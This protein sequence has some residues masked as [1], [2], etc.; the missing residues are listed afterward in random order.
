MKREMLKGKF[1]LAMI[2]GLIC[3]IPYQEAFAWGGDRTNRGRYY[4]HAGRFYRWGD[5]R[6]IVVNPPLGAIVTALPFGYVSV[7][8][9]GVRYYRYN[10]V[11][12]RH[13]PSGYVIVAD[14][15]VN[16]NIAYLPPAAGSAGRIVVNVP[17]ANGGYT[18]V[19]LLRYN[20]GY[21]GP[22][23]EYY[24]GNPTVDQLRALYGR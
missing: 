15:T 18:P 13:C 16:P 20:N 3:V 24:P 12:Y 4:Y 11:Y 22:Q 23:G 19:Q 14:P 5:S 21:I 9:G 6:Y 8:F 2:L 10:H 7:V 1:W 17:N